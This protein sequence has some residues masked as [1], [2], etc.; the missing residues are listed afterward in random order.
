[1]SQTTTS[2]GL[3]RRIA[4]GLEELSGAIRKAAIYVLENPNEI[5]V[6]SVRKIAE[7]SHVHPNTLIR[8]ARSFGFDGYEDFREVF[9]DDVRQ[10]G[11]GF[12]DRAR[13]LQTFAK[14]G[15]LQ[16]LYGAMARTAIE[17]IEAT[18]ARTDATQVEAA[19]MSIVKAGKTLVLGLGASS[20]LARNF[21]YL[22]GMAIDNVRAIPEP[23][24]T[25]LDDVGH[26]GPG[27]VLMA[28]GFRP[29]R[30]EVIAAVRAA[31]DQGVTLIGISDSPAAPIV[32]LAHHGFV[33]QA[34]TP[35]FFTSSV[36]VNA[37]LEAFVAFIVADASAEVIERI[38]EI[39]VRRHRLG[40]YLD[41][42]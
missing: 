35:L 16:E 23:G 28:I 29:Y 40:I 34:K 22:T 7:A 6:S 33:A 18:Y 30:S 36:A 32:T 12:P 13:H 27:D 25:P 11:T 24:S 5:S 26:L 21:A 14:G 10:G 3:L 42:K 41:E 31:L 8:L 37:I 39:D 2:H 1:M 20:S 19:A 9:R 15:R 4:E 17:N 38:E